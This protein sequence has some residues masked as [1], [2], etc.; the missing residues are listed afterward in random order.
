MTYR[1]ALLVAVL[2]VPSGGLEAQ[3][4]G[5]RVRISEVLV[6]DV[7]DV[8][9][10]G[11][12]LKDAG[13]IPY[14]QVTKLEVSA[15]K[16]SYW[17]RGLAVGAGAGLLAGAAWGDWVV[18]HCDT[19]DQ[20]RTPECDRQLTTAILVPTFAGSV[21]GWLLGS[22]IHTDV[23]R[24]VPIGGSAAVGFVVQRRGVSLWKR[25]PLG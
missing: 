20:F 5:D 18:A 24:V 13:L 8:D 21:L 12:Y 3:F 19:G 17:K 14:W 25:Q 6:D 11:I 4:P 9:S 23:W 10:I 2:M 1:A 15:G 7:V 16:R 22:A